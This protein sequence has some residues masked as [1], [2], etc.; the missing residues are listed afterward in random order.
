MKV[1]KKPS[2]GGASAHVIIDS[3]TVT[4][5]TSITNPVAVTGTFFQAT[6][7]VSSADGAQATIGVTTGAKVVTD[8]N[9]T[10]QQYLRGL[11]SLIA[12]TLTVTGTVVANL[13]T[14]AG[15]ATEVTLALIKAKTDNID[16]ALSTRLKPADTLTAVTTVTT[17][18]G[19]TN[20]V[21][22]DDNAGSLTVDGAVTANAGTNLN[23]SALN[24]EA[25]QALVRAKTDNL[26]VALSTRLKP[27]DTLAAVTAIT[28][29]V[30]VDDNA[31]SLTVDGAVTVS[32]T[33]AVSGNVEVVN[34]VGNPLP[35]NGT[36]EITNDVG[37]AIPISATSLPLPT[38]AATEATLAS[39]HAA[40]AA[41]APSQLDVIAGVLKNIDTTVNDTTVGTVRALPIDS[42]TGRVMVDT[43]AN[44]RDFDGVTALY[45]ADRVL[46]RLAEAAALNDYIQSMQTI[47]A[48]EWESSQ[49]MGFEIR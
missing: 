18:T 36:V 30:H 4:A 28:N 7:P 27:A 10:L 48:S 34:D 22:V 33:V 24:L 8:A 12:G 21:H 44:T 15:V 5:V 37:N 16:V 38:G 35:V 46:R 20:V 11:V 32:G 40:S 31:G 49:R 9:G 2:T 3:G 14:I 29:V 25:T 47:I 43:E 13:G 45:S 39:T 17:V 6:Q 1:V 23:T 26:D 41:A 42:T 19:I